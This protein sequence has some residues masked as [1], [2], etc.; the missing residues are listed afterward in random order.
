[1]E[2]LFFVHGAW[3]NEYAWDKARNLLKNKGY[4]TAAVTLA[5]NEPERSEEHTSEL[6]SLE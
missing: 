5:G 6:Q 2:K 3:H 4:Q 1:M